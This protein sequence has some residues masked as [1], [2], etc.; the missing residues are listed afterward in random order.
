MNIEKELQEAV[1]SLDA[2]FNRGDVEALMAFYA[3]DATM[4]VQPGLVV[5]GHGAIREVFTQLSHHGM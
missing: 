4:V 3:E 1:A 2:A 5:S